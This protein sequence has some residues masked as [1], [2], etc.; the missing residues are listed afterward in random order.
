VTVVRGAVDREALAKA[1]ELRPEQAVI[2]SQTVGY[3]GE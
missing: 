1:M 2:L 3:R